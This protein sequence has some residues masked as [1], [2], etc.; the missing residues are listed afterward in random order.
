MVQSLFLGV[1]ATALS[2]LTAVFIE[3][4]IDQYIP[5][6]NIPMILG[7]GSAL[8]LVLLATGVSRYLRQRFLIRLNQIVSSDVNEDFLSHLYRLPLRF[9]ESRA[10]GDITT[11]I[12]DGL[13]I[14]QGLLQI[15]GAAVIDG[16]LVVGS[17]LFLFLIAPPLGVIALISVPLY[18][19]ILLRAAT[20]LRTEQSAALSAY[21]KVESGYIDSMKGISDVLGF[22]VSSFFARTNATLHRLFSERVEK[23]GRIHA[24]LTLFSEL[25]GG[26]LMIIALTRGALL[27]VAEDLLLGQLMAGYSLLAGTVPSAERLVQAW[28]GFQETA[29]SAGRFRDLTLPPIQSQAGAPEIAIRGG[30]RLEALS[31][32]WP[33]GKRQLHDLNFTLPVGRVT[34]LWGPNGSGKT[35]LVR[36]LNRS[37]LPTE[38][39][40]L[41]DGTCRGTGTRC[42]PQE[43]RRFSLRSASLQWVRSAERVTGALRWISG[44]GVLKT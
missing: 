7:T 26:T 44:I 21:G 35:T 5:Q 17:A 33:N 10:I 8:L 20:A 36:V 32:D 2:L 16:L 43:C 24:G 3:W 9:F 30:L 38:G 18:T 13:R 34:R 28:A 6:R 11:R 23:L 1:V 41:V 19:A 39:R 22:G 4:L 14:Q 29:V 12:A 27:V 25:A 15:G 42:V 31:L 40:I 37:Y